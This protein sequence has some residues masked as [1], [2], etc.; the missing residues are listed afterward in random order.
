MTGESRHRLLAPARVK[1]V[2]KASILGELLDLGEYPGLI[3][4]SGGASRVRGEFIE[5]EALESVIEALDEEEGPEF[6][7]E[8]VNAALD[9]GGNHFAWAWLLA[10]GH[11]STRVITSGDWRNRNSQA[12]DD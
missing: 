4:S 7:R 12:A 2:R 8:V 6:R 11:P 5:V 1:S 10:A 3:L 9:E